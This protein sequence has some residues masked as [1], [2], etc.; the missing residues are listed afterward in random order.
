MGDTTITP[1]RFGATLTF[2]DIG[3]PECLNERIF[4]FLKKYGGSSRISK[5]TPKL[6]AKRLNGQFYIRLSEF[7][8]RGC[9]LLL[10]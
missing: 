3:P 1:G 7:S 9:E 4:Y 8:A 2:S 5:T 10:V 6:T